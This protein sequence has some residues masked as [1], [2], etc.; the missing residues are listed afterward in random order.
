MTVRWPY[1][2]PRDDGGARH[3]T[4]GRAIPDLALPAT[5]GTEV[6]L[7]RLE[8]TTL[9]FVY[10][11]TGRPG[12][13]DPSG[14]DDIPGAH[15]STPEALGFRNLHSGFR[16]SGVGVYGLSSQTT[17]W[18]QEFAARQALPYP[19]LSD[20][21]GD[22]ARALRLPTFEAGGATYLSRLTLVIEDG[23]ISRCVYPVFPPDAH[24]REMLAMLEAARGYHRESRLQPSAK[25]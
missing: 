19:L 11:W 17:A 8:G 16:A 22:M 4:K 23:L 2:A 25:S 18:Q 20:A 1:A 21:A 13:A 15:G 6:Q 7:A 3:L 12:S 24:A 10:P 5:D 9:V 14:W